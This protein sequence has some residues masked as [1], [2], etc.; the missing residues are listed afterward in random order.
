[1]P[2]SVLSC[3]DGGD[4]IRIYCL[5]GRMM[6]F[7]GDVG[8]EMNEQFRLALLK[9]RFIGLLGFLSRPKVAA[10]LGFIHTTVDDK[11]L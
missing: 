11:T 10:R 4:S 8:E 1:M 5:S 3:C 2:S 6:C 7:R 9:G